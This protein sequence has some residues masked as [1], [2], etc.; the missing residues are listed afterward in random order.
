MKKFGI[1]RTEE[2]ILKENYEFLLIFLEANVR[3]ISAI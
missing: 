1:Q 2:L 3:S